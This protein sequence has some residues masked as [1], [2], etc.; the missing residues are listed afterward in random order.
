[1]AEWFKQ[2]LLS[3]FKYGLEKVNIIATQAITMIFNLYGK[4]LFRIEDDKLIKS[5]E[6]IN[7]RDLF[8]LYPIALK[9]IEQ[10]VGL[11]TIKIESGIMNDFV[12]SVP[13]KSLLSESTMINIADIN[14][15]VSLTKK[16]DLHVSNTL[17]EAKSYLMESQKSK[18]SVGSN[19]S[20]FVKSMGNDDLFSTY[21][22]IKK[23]LIKY[24]DQIN[25]NIKLITIKLQNHFIITLEDLIYDTRN[26]TIGRISVCPLDSESNKLLEI[27]TFTYNDGTINMDKLIANQTIINYIPV[28]HTDNSKSDL[29]LNVNIVHLEYV[30][31]QNQLIVDGA[32]I[33]VQPNNIII[34]KIDSIVLDD[35]L[36]FKV[37]NPQSL[38]NLLEFNYGDSVLKFNKKLYV[39]IGNFNSIQ[40]WVI[41]SMETIKVFISKIVVEKILDSQ[42]SENSKSIPKQNKFTIN[43]LESIIVYDDDTFDIS[44]KYVMISDVNKLVDVKLKYGDVTLSSHKVIIDQKKDIHLIN[45]ICSSNS[46]NLQS[47]NVEIHKTNEIGGPS[48]KTPSVLNIM[49]SG[50]NV[51]NIVQIIDYVINLVTKFTDK[52]T[53]EPNNK[54]TQSIQKSNPLSVNLHVF[55]SNISI[56]YTDIVFDLFIKK[57]TICITERYAKNTF[58][59][60]LMNKYLIA[61]TESSYLSSKDLKID[62]LRLYLDPELFDKLNY[63]FGTLK[64][65]QVNTTEVEPEMHISKEGLLEIKNAMSQSMIAESMVELH[66]MVNDLTDHIKSSFSSKTE[67]IEIPGVN[68]LTKSFAS[69]SNAIIDEYN[70]I[71]EDKSDLTII[72]KSIHVYLFDK[73]NIHSKQETAQSAQAFL[74]GVLKNVR[75]DKITDIVK[76]DNSGPIIKLVQSESGMIK[77]K[78]KIKIQTKFNV[79]VETGA[80]IDMLSHDTEWKYFVKA[81]EKQHLISVNVTTQDDKCKIKIY[82]SPLMASVREE[83]IIRLLAF[84][85][86]SHQ[87]PQNKPTFIDYFE[88]NDIDIIVNY[89]PIILSQVVGQNV[90]SLKDFKIRLSGQKI[91]NTDSINKLV[92]I[93]GTR[94][95]NEINPDN[96]LQF[97]PNIKII[98]PYATPI[99]RFFNITG[100]Y[101]NKRDNKRKL[102][103]LTSNL[104]SGIT[105]VSELIKTGID[106]VWDY[107]N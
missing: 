99:V 68:V 2:L 87:I 78:K 60:I 24:F 88:I 16:S 28:I 38:S 21:N 61:R 101:F 89:H 35:I 84:F 77:D 81:L 54:L 51:T 39:K 25:V 72:I 98:K 64:L 22:E 52:Q 40:N 63:L 59:D 44:S 62:A 20:N 82:L 48:G 93:I 42:S 17:I 4:R 32:D 70:P 9:E 67:L 14:L 53:E 46:F 56:K 29:H 41:D 91:R 43:N 23:L 30:S 57:S 7:D 66:V 74:C 97:I 80:I 18:D 11:N 73:M 6:C 65:N 12:L 37:N 10:D 55:E 79:S 85:S 34:K 86:D 100:R 96:V 102:R 3:P 1:M 105:I 95:K 103:F 27:N 13:W 45:M 106:Q 58:V 47:N 71:S 69:L 83:T 92:T 49:F 76:E 8:Y 15:V 36:L 50:A 26:L 19:E 107:F 5:N 94:W 75:F 31:K 90:L 33:V 104:N